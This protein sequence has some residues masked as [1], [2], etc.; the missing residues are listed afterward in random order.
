MWLG[1]QH[2]GTQNLS[3]FQ[4]FFSH[5]FLFNYC[6]AMNFSHF[7]YNLSSFLIQFTK[8]KYSIRVTRYDMLT[9]RDA[10][11]PHTQAQSHIVCM[12]TIVRY[13]I[14]KI[15]ENYFCTC[16]VKSH[17]GASE[18]MHTYRINYQLLFKWMILSINILSQKFDAYPQLHSQLDKLE[19]SSSTKVF[20]LA[21]L[22]N[23]M[24]YSINIEKFPLL[25][26]AHTYFYSFKYQL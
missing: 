16:I 21:M 26:N 2:V 7:V 23:H 9:K 12:D 22:T 5:N 19:R 13:F 20:S 14:S 4:S 1:L 6:M 10:L 17:E 18:C 3:L 15:L 11:C 8:W 24:T 25:H